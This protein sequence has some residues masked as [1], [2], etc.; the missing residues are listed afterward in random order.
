MLVDRMPRTEYER[1]NGKWYYFSLMAAEE[2]ARES[3]EK[4]IL[5]TGV[6]AEVGTVGKEGCKVYRVWREEADDL[7]PQTGR[8]ASGYPDICVQI[9]RGMSLLNENGYELQPSYHFVLAS[10]IM[11]WKPFKLPGRTRKHVPGK[12]SVQPAARRRRRRVN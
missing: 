2:K 1:E 11:E 12:A 7:F 3:V 9:P 5:Q 6:R 8:P 4:Q 10:T